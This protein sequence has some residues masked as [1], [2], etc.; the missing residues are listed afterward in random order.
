MIMK[1]GA[2]CSD[3]NK[4]QH[5]KKLFLHDVYTSSFVCFELMNTCMMYMLRFYIVLY[6]LY[7]S[8]MKLVEAYAMAITA[9]VALYIR[10]VILTDSL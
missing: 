9:C 5:Q 1:V 6:L 7:V 3:L 2:S 8:S 4:Q 10:G